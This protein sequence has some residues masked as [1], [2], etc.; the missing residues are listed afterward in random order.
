MLTRTGCL[1]NRTHAET[2]RISETC[3]QTKLILMRKA[4]IGTGA[5]YTPHMGT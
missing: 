2:T 4:A 1:K 5:Y 3:N